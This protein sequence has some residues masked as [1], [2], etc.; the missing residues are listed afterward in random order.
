ML[1]YTK[2]I[3]QVPEMPLKWQIA[4]LANV[5]WATTIFSIPTPKLTKAA[6]SI[7]LLGEHTQALPQ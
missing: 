7:S 5:I 6:A 4:E 3:C 2:G 1:K